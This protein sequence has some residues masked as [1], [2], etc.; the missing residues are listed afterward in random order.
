MRGTGMCRDVAS[1]EA[2]RKFMVEI[3]RY[4][5]RAEGV[6]GESRVDSSWEKMDSLVQLEQDGKNIAALPLLGPWQASLVDSSTLLPSDSTSQP[7]TLCWGPV[8]TNCQL[9]SR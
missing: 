1:L 6:E 9:Q 5:G 2:S 4:M 7:S 8:M 3:T